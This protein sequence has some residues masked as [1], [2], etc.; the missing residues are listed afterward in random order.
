MVTTLAGST[1]S[2][3]G[4][5]DGAGTS[6]RFYTPNFIAI[7]ASN[8]IFVADA[9]NHKIRKITPAGVVTT[10]AGSGSYGTGTAATFNSPCGIAIDS[11]GDFY[12][13]EQTGNRV[14]KI[15]PAGVVTSI[16]G[17]E[18]SGA[19]DGTGSAAT[20]NAPYQI[21]AHSDGLLY[22][23]DRGNSLIRKVSKAGVVDRIR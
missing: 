4:S 18:S 19:V 16:A 8:N 5:A 10:F 11:L 2:Y 20:F 6:A 9:N 3:S 14:R 1:N 23:A 21:T 17:S 7:D 12:V 13:T 15:T 22:V